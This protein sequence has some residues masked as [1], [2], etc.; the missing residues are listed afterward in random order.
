MSKIF[1]EIITADIAKSIDYFLY[2][3]TDEEFYWLT[4]T[5]EEIVEKTQCKDFISTWHIGIR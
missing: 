5:F 1:I 2:E 3:C 4:E